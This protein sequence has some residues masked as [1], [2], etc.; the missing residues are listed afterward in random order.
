MRGAAP[1]LNEAHPGMKIIGL[2]ILCY[3]YET[4]TDKYEGGVKMA[5]PK[6]RDIIQ[7]AASGDW[8]IPEFQREFEWKYEKVAKLFDSLYKDLP[9]GLITVWNTTRYNE[10]QRKTPSGRRPVWVVDGQQRIVSLC[11]LSGTKPNWMDNN[12][13]NEVFT[14][15]RIF[16]NIN[17]AGESAI[18]RQSLIARVKI[19]IDEL[20]NKQPAQALRY[21]QEKCKEHDV[22]N[23]EDGSNFAVNAIPILE[24]VVHVAEVGEDKGVEEVAD[25]Y[26]RLNQQG[27]RLRQAQIM[28]AYV[29]QYN[30]G[31]I[32]EEFY[33]FLENL[34]YRDEWELDPAH[35]LQVATILAKGKARVGEATPDM[36]DSGVKQ[37]WPTLRQAID[38]SILRLWTNGISDQDMVPSSYTLIALF[39]IQGKF[40]TKPSF[41]FDQLFQWFILAN[42]SG[43][44]GD[45]PL[46]TLSHDSG[47]I[48]EAPNFGEAIK[49]LAIIDWPDEKL[50]DLVRQTF[51]DNSSQALLLHVLLWS[52]EAK[53]L[54]EGLSIPALTQAPKNL[55]PHWHHIV[56]KAWGKRHGFEDCDKTANVTRLCAETNVRKLRTMPPWEYVPRFDISKEALIQHLVPDKYAEKFVKGQPLSP[57]EFKDFLKE[58]EEI[59]VQKGASLL[60]L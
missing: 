23:T 14:K 26:T 50:R 20:I 3:N 55:E 40:M 30:P 42:L 49:E 47:I 17:Q 27:T 43:R 22:L 8:S 45:A 34:Q 53:D 41:N 29:S 7:Y 12:K 48:Y 4:F 25:L 57:A 56:P 59:I 60:G 5:D 18:G 32:R 15:N 39:A 31:W 16:L 58:R 52:A 2:D 46:E 51:R 54:V 28:L 38:D 44:Y 36:W 13:W 21:V 24:H 11:I 19:P 6:M 37:V 10:P 33:P 9:I 1:P 35:V